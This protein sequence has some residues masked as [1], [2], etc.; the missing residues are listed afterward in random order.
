MESGSKEAILPSHAKIPAGVGGL[1]KDSVVLC[2][3]IRV[4]DN[5]RL[6]RRIGNI[7]EKNLRTV[8]VAL[9][10]ILGLD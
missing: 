5:K 7:E 1:T 3:Q 4:I 2:E 10:V 6:E 8:A 9:E